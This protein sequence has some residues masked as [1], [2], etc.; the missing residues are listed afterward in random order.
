MEGV[1]PVVALAPSQVY[2]KELLRASFEK[3]RV[4]GSPS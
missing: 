1:V 4:H 2:E 3:V